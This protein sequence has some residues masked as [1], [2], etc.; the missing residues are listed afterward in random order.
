V[1][2][3]CK[4]PGSD[5]VS[6]DEL[7]FLIDQ[8]TVRKM[9]IGGVDV[10]T[11]KILSKKE[12]RKKYTN[13]TEEKRKSERQIDQPTTSTYKEGVSS[14]DEDS[15]SSRLVAT[16]SDSDTEQS[17]HECGHTGQQMRIPLPNLAMQADR[18]GV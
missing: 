7:P 12:L 11:S 1:H 5:K 18:F 13:Q 3:D 4:C 15:K 8:R 16:D 9:Y 6:K 2:V 14:S 17:E 10:K